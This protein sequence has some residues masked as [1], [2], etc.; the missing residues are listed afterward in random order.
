[1]LGTREFVSK[2]PSAWQGTFSDVL[3]QL[4]DAPGLFAIPTCFA[5]LAPWCVV[6]ST[7]LRHG[8]IVWCLRSRQSSVSFLVSVRCFQPPSTPLRAR[9]HRPPQGV[10]NEFSWH[11]DPISDCR[12]VTVSGL[13]LDVLRASAD[14]IHAA[15]LSCIGISALQPGRLSAFMGST[16][17][18]ACSGVLLVEPHLN[19]RRQV[20]SCAAFATLVRCSPRHY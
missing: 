20:P 13:H 14:W 11:L 19:V 1:M 2:Q 9:T 12:D 8:V 18:Q 6:A 15:S 7:C 5:L 3:W 10:V 4:L 17:S 16:C